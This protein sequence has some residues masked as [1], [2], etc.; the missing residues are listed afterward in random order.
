MQKACVYSSGSIP[1]SLWKDLCTTTFS[2]NRSIFH[3][4]TN[5]NSW[6]RGS[7][8]ML[9]TTGN[10]AFPSSDK[11]HLAGSVKRYYTDVVCNFL[12]GQLMFIALIPSSNHPNMS[13]IQNHPQKTDD[14]ETHH[15]NNHPTSSNIIQISKHPFPIQMLTKNRHLLTARKCLKCFT[16]RQPRRTHLAFASH[17]L[18]GWLVGLM[19]L[20]MKILLERFFSGN[21]GDDPG[22]TYCINVYSCIMIWS[23]TTGQRFDHR[24]ENQS[25]DKLR[26][27]ADGSGCIEAI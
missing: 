13:I 4:Q 25:Q 22:V 21:S 8:S 16:S 27:C 17:G 2:R 19:E 24:R 20:P 3:Q 11:H 26:V 6:T 1:L 5:K 14:K 23:K 12:F 10:Q 18:V 7:I 15:Q 9:Q